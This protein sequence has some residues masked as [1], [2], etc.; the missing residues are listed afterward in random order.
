VVRINV[1]FGAMNMPNDLITLREARHLLG[2]SDN[3]V[4]SLVKAG[5]LKTYTNL[6]DRRK[7]LVSR[8]EVE[9]L[10]VPRAEAA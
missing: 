8:A 2:V 4:T 6:L 5:L 7:K 9:E 1:E 10:K 3:K